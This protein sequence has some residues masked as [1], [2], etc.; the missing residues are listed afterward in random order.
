MKKLS[1]LV[2][3]LIALQQMGYAVIE[4]TSTTPCTAG[5]CDGTADITATGTAGPFT[6]VW[7]NGLT[8]EDATGLCPGDYTVEVIYKGGCSVI[9][10][11]H[12]EGIA[13]T[14]DIAPYIEG[15]CP[16]QDG[17]V[18][19][20][21][22]T[23]PDYN[24]TYHWSNGSDQ[25]G[26]SNLPIG[27]YCVTITGWQNGDAVCA[28]NYCYTVPQNPSPTFSVSSLNPTCYGASTGTAIINCNAPP[29]IIQLDN[30]PNTLIT[31]FT[32]IYTLT[33]LSGGF[34]HVRLFSTAYNPGCWSNNQ[35]IYVEESKPTL[36]ADIQNTCEHDGEIH[37]TGANS[38]SVIYE[39]SNHSNSNSLD[40]LSPG[41]YNVTATDALGCTA[42]AS[43]SVGSDVTSDLL[44][45]DCRWR[46]YTCHGVEIKREEVGTITGYDAATCTM[47]IY[48]RDGTELSTTYGY[49]ESY[50]TGNTTCGG[51][52]DYYDTCPC[53]V[54]CEY[55]TNCIFPNGQVEQVSSIPAT[56]TESVSGSHCQVYGAVYDG[57]VVYYRCNGDIVASCCENFAKTETIPIDTVLHRTNSE[58][59]FHNIDGS[60]E[61]IYTP[62]ETDSIIRSYNK[63]VIPVKFSVAPNP[64]QKSFTVSLRL[65]E[66]DNITFTL[67]DLTGRVILVKQTE[68]SEG[69]QHYDINIDTDFASGVYILKAHSTSHYYN[70]VKLIHNP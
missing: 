57:L 44:E 2:F 46:V 25:N 28:S 5:M 41:T 7:S 10:D 6:F 36:T 67:T 48:C 65:E 20:L 54:V 24:F 23:Q 62:A 9:L 60:Y 34:H 35:V 63:G 8:T 39:W 19:K 4:V 14:P 37:L 53:H 12:I 16:G 58:L 17:G 50:Y 18:V 68:L 55:I 31:S 61:R 47:T 49:T 66:S 27:S 52:G 45:G 1:L 56:R 70:T 15:T 13:C 21:T 22:V 30:D 38:V 3:L 64:F 33:H 59:I 40:N 26:I 32:S 43:F 11:V 29:Y 69:L 42:S 51:F